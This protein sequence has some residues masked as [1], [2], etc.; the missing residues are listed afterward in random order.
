MV[1]T[2]LDTDLFQ[3]AVVSELSKLEGT[4][5]S[6]QKDLEVR[7]GQSRTTCAGRFGSLLGFK[8][9]DKTFDLCEFF[10]SRKTPRA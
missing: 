10:G 3:A 5:T 1:W 9:W 8:T 2:C 4:L 7:C 6:A